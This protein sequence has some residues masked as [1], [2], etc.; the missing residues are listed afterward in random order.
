[1]I[2]ASPEKVFSLI[3]DFHHWP[4]WAQPDREDAAMK[5]TYSGADSGVGAIT[6]WQGAGATGK[7]QA[8]IVES[9]PSQKV[10]VRVDWVKPMQLQNV[11]EFVLQ[12]SG[13][14]TNVTW[15][16]HGPNLYIMKL[17]GVF[18]NMDKMMRKHFED[19]LKNLKEV[20]EK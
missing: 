4:E 12:P 18:I 2:Q 9:V 16:M 7:G 1:M 3:N 15:S 19:G 11:N 10:T 20:A 14:A 17:M 5:R 8:E 13:S 6:D